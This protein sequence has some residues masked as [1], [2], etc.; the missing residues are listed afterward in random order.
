MTAPE[1]RV[2][3]LSPVPTR[4]FLHQLPTDSR[5]WGNCRFIFDPNERDYDWLAVYE[6]LP[7]LPDIPRN[8]HCEVLASPSGHSILTTSEPSSI[9][10][11]GNPY[12]HQFGC[13]LTSQA[14]W[15]LPHSDRI[16]SQAGLIWFY[17][18]GRDSIRSFET[19]AEHPPLRKQHDL[20]M[21]FSAKRMRV[22]LHN[23]RFQF[24]HGLIEQ[25]PE[26]HVFGRG[27]RPLDDKADA[28]DDY[29]YHIAI[30]NHIEDHHWTEKLA[31]AF[32]G[33]TLPFYCGCPNA[34]EYFPADSFI[35]I[36]MRDPQA[37]ARIIREAIANGEYEKRLPAIM[38]ARRRVL[39]E[40]NLFAVLAR[41]IEV[42]HDPRATNDGTQRLC[43]RHALRRHSPKVWISD[44]FGKIRGRWHHLLD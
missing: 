39:Y 28:L 18:A 29:R 24:M 42:R 38:E 31:D 37:A 23:R 14:A 43:S 33:L 1:I 32:L 35:P 15:A 17:G 3:L 9:K 8:Q 5:C 27:Y 41:E 10:H 4:F 36:D 16:H 25:I 6:D 34:A 19:I 2:K 44:F 11:Y 13:V 40:H 12:T 21:V 30:E 26:M 22:T 7:G 20:A